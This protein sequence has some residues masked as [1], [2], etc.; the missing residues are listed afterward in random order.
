MSTTPT[1]PI[2][3]MNKSELEDLI[4]RVIREELARIIHLPT[5]HAIDD[6]SHEG[7]MTR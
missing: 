3:S 5:A 1:E 6:W 7:R 2:V 4:R